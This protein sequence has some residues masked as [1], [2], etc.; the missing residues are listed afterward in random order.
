MCNTLMENHFTSGEKQPSTRLRSTEEERPYKIEALACDRNACAQTPVAL[1]GP[2]LGN[3]SASGPSRKTL[4]RLQL[5]PSVD[6]CDRLA[7]H[8]DGSSSRWLVS[9]ALTILDDE[10]S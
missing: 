5:P 8:D 7:A 4:F 1:R 3:P 10:M 6:V 9:W 2:G